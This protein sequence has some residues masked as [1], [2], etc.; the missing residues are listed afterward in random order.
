MRKGKYL[1]CP[2]CN[3]IFYR[4]PHRIKRAK[5][6]CCSHECHY[7]H[8]FTMT[9]QRLSILHSEPL[10]SLVYRWYVVDKISMREI[11]KKLEINYRTTQKLFKKFKIPQRS[12]HDRVVLQWDDKRREYFSKLMSKR[13]K[14]KPGWS[15]GLTKKDH[16]GIKKQAESK[17]GVKNPMYGKRG[18]ASPQYKNGKYTAKKKRYWGTSEYQQWRK[19]V[20]ERDNYT[21]QD[22]GDN[23]GGNLN[24][25]HIKPW[26]GFP[27]LRYAVSNGVTLCAKCHRI[28][29]SSIKPEIA[30]RHI[31]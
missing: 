11:T 4:K 24:A 16:P 1:I 5:I 30:H 14:G 18:K 9:I 3:K 25:H 20:Y 12:V 19:T 13:L 31:G 29:H 26:V 22:C 6:N 23:K 2:I 15:K 17:I 10:K 7:E 27:K 28:A 21:C 8:V